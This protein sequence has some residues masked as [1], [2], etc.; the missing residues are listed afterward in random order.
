MVQRGSAVFVPLHSKR[1]ESLH[2]ELQNNLRDVVKAP[3]TQQDSRGNYWPHATVINKVDQGRADETFATLR[4]TGEAEKLVHG[5]VVGLDLWWYRG[6]P[7]E[8]I[9]TFSFRA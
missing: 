9:R 6:G 1:I 4:S 8:H 3:L 7:W 5:E 2:Q